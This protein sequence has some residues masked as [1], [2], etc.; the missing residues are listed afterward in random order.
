MQVNAGRALALHLNK[1][2]DCVGSD[3]ASRLRIVGPRT[4]RRRAA[5]ESPSSYQGYDWKLR[6]VR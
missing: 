5:A 6:N 2:F 3:N 4:T 1:E